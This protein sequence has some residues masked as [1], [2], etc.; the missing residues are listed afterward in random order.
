MEIKS[1]I[2][3]GCIEGLA[4]KGS[5]ERWGFGQVYEFVKAGG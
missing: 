3:G 5:V 2:T 4:A 1:R